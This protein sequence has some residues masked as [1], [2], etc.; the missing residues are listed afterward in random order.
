[1]V[2]SLIGS[3]FVRTKRCMFSYTGCCRNLLIVHSCVCKCSNWCAW[4]M[5]KSCP[6]SL[7]VRYICPNTSLFVHTLLFPL[8]IQQQSLHF[9]SCTTQMC[10]PSPVPPVFPVPL[11]TG[12]AGR[13]GA[14]PPADCTPPDACS[15]QTAKHLP[16]FR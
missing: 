2:A 5:C 9:L 6:T 11:S 16:L 10:G 8:P 7:S 13:G 4:R 12:P 3:R 14:V 1:M 15:T